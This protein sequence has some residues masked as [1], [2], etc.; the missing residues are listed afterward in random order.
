MMDER[1][2][3]RVRVPASTANLGPGFDT[4]GMA[5]SLYARIE[6]KESR[7][8]RI[9]LYGDQLAGIPADKTNLIYK[10][11]QQL[12]AEAGV[13]VPELDIAMQSD[14]PLTRGL[15]SSASAIVGALAAAN[16][17]IGEPFGQDDLFQM[18]TRLEDHPDNAGASLFGG[19]IS[20][21][22]N[23]KRATGIKLDPP[24]DLTLL[25]AVPDFH[26]STEKARNLLPDT[27]SRKDAVFNVSHASLLTAALATGRLD[28][29]GEA[30][31]DRL[32][33]PYRSDL[34]PGMAHILRDAPKHGALG[35]A[36]SGAGPAMI[37][38]V[39]RN[40]AD[41]EKL[42]SFLL[43]TFREAGVSARTLWLE[44]DREGVRIVG[45][46]DPLNAEFEL[47]KGEVRS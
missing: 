4:L 22:W 37:A 15:G 30:M 23:G 42:E 46:D 13:R 24:D 31:Q 44:P 18:A 3:V 10:I 8:T 25:L 43:N 47:F 21:V 2:T 26:L 11:A 16:A 9:R 36:L 35:V 38:F 45:P 33:Q 12:F 27:V 7:E 34:V 19:I 32:H 20:A 14:I 39:D 1:G 17:L 28:L 29:I 41:G 40:R 5:L 6:M